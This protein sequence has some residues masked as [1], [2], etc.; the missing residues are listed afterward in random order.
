MTSLATIHDMVADMGLMISGVVGAGASSLPE[1]AASVVL[2]SPDEPNFWNVLTGDM[3][4]VGPRPEIRE[5]IQGGFSHPYS[6]RS[7]TGIF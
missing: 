1:G 2:L 7:D 3:A 6:L 4:L 5:F